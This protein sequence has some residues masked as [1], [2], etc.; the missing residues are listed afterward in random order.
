VRPHLHR[1]PGP[2]GQDTGR[3]QP[4]HR[5][6]ERIVIPLLLGPVIFGVGRGGQRVQHRCDGLSALGRQV[7]V[8]DAGA[9]E[10]GDQ[11]HGPVVEDLAGV[12]VGGC[13]PGLLV[14][15]PVQLGQ[16][17]Q[18]HAGQGRRDEFVVREI[19]LVL[20][21]P[22]GPLAQDPGH[23]LRQVPGRQRRQ[24]PRVVSGPP[25]PRGVG[26]RRALGHPGLVD[27]PGPRAVIGV[28][29]VTLAGAE[30]A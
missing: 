23:R 2:L 14:D 11:P 4:A 25:H 20:R 28:R 12:L 10:R 7:A 16:V 13:G 19:A 8:Q 5:L 9:L 21:E 22:V 17:L 27:Q 6:L 3:D 24:N 30:R 26:H 29:R 1:L 18:A 15:L